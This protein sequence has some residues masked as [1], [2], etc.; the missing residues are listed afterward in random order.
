MCS[1]LM[2]DCL[3]LKI[4]YRCMRVSLLMHQCHLQ[5][6]TNSSTSIEPPD[7]IVTMKTNEGSIPSTEDNPTMN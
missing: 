7:Y 4:I 3:R 1:D 5:R 2:R 6:I